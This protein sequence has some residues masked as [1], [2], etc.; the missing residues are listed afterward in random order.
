ML[1]VHALWDSEMKSSGNRGK[2]YVCKVA[3]WKLSRGTF[4]PGL[5]QKAGA[6][7]DNCCCLRASA[8][9]P[10]DHGYYSINDCDGVSDCSHDVVFLPLVIVFFGSNSP[11]VLLGKL[12][13]MSV[14]RVFYCAAGMNILKCL[15][16]VQV[17]RAGNLR[18][19]ATQALEEKCP[20]LGTNASKI[21][22]PALSRYSLPQIWHLCIGPHPPQPAPS[23]HR[24]HRDTRV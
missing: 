24:C 5:L 22:L 14:G 12:L 18:T 10:Y 2:A 21:L 7:E 13:K 11:T 1:W 6:W 17:A 20:T 3:E 9:Y 8:V 15:V 23:R 16:D 19:S 4:R